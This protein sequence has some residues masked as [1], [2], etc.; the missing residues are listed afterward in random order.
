MIDTKMCIWGGAGDSENLNDG[1][2]WDSSSDTWSAISDVGAPNKTA[3]HAAIWTVK[4]MCVW[5][6]YGS[7][8]NNSYQGGCWNPTTDTWTKIYSG[9]ESGEVSGRQDM[10]YFW[11]GEKFC[12]FGRQRSGGIT[13]SDGMCYFAID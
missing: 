10:S 13:I 5:G 3:A 12:I 2:C 7:I 8:N 9:F 4:N 1:K 6:G 11:T